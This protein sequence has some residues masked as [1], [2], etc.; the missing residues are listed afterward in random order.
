[1]DL[2]GFALFGAH[3]LQVTAQIYSDTL[4]LCSLSP[5]TTSMCYFLAVVSVSLALAKRNFTALLRESTKPLLLLIPQHDFPQSRLSAAKQEG[6]SSNLG[7][8]ADRSSHMSLGAS[9]YSGNPAGPDSP[10]LL[11][12]HWAIFSSLF[13][14]VNLE[15]RLTERKKEQ[16]KINADIFKVKHFIITVLGDTLQSPYV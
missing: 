13:Q 1:M 16:N 6:L 12:L 5:F 4:H 7:T 2:M 15:S 9:S 10:A 14:V 11:P 8:T 3:Q